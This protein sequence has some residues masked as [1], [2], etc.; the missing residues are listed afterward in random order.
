MSGPV[1]TIAVPH[2]WAVRVEALHRAWAEHF[3]ESLEA[4]RRVF[5]VALIERGLVSLEKY[6]K[7]CT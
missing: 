6:L 1:V 3:G 7:G 4:S 2:G 5:E